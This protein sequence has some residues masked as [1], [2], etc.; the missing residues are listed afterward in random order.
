MFPN[1]NKMQ[2]MKQTTKQLESKQPR[3]ENLLKNHRQLDLRVENETNWMWNYSI[4]G[5]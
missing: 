3:G 2:N 5:C 1:D 4:A